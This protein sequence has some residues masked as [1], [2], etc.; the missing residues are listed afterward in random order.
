[1]PI[2]VPETCLALLYLPHSS[3]PRSYQA[4]S[5]AVTRLQTLLSVCPL[6][7]L[8]TTACLHLS[9]L[10]SHFT[11]PLVRSVLSKPTRASSKIS[12]Q[13]MIWTRFSCGLLLLC[14]AYGSIA[15]EL[16]ACTHAGLVHVS[17][18]MPCSFLWLEGPFLPLS[19]W[20]SLTALSTTQLKIAA[21]QSFP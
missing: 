10:A 9:Q 4:G 12:K 3:V 1:M 13:M 18:C 19:V 14:T 15:G 2:E 17:V 21:L 8:W 16:T 6:P 5:L 11:L 20:K 7:P